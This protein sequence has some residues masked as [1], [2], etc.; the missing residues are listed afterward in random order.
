MPG[1]CAAA[2]RCADDQLCTAAAPCLPGWMHQR[3]YYRPALFYCSSAAVAYCAPLC[4]R[5]AGV[6][7]AGMW[8]RGTRESSGRGPAATT[9]MWPAVLTGGRPSFEAAGQLPAGSAL[10]LCRSA[11][12]GNID[13]IK[14]PATGRWRT[15]NR[16]RVDAKQP[17]AAARAR[18]G[19][20]QR[21]VT[22]ARNEPGVAV[23]ARHLPSRAA[24]RPI[25]LV[26]GAG[27]CAMVIILHLAGGSR[28]TGVLP[29]QQG[30]GTV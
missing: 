22:G 16:Q 10:A 5:L 30:S 14:R 20:L 21:G 19:E 29:V 17:Q 3:R 15:N 1:L 4:R 8:P 28:S 13:Q 26:S 12:G 25:F 7:F 9:A 18:P 6:Y 11:S 24:V 2:R 23:L 27:V